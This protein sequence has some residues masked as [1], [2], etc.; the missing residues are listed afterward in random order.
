MTEKELSN[1]LI[2]STFNQFPSV[3]T[4]SSCCMNLNSETSR[5]RE[6]QKHHVYKSLRASESRLVFE[7]L[8]ESIDGLRRTLF[9]VVKP[10]IQNSCE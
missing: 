10:Y 9:Q 8:S 3:F 2:A 5:V 6:W 4:S 7:T 1:I